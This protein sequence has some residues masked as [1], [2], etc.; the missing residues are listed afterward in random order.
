MPRTGG[1]Y[2]IA[3]QRTIVSFI[4]ALVVAA[5]LWASPVLAQ[6]G[7]APLPTAP[8]ADK[9]VEG[10]PSQAP[11]SLPGPDN[12]ASPLEPYLVTWLLPIAGIIVAVG[13]VVVDKR[14]RQVGGG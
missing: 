9:A 8:G 13:F 5:A 11:A 2:E 10:G 1:G 14:L 12:G 7:P 3:M 6:N 4:A